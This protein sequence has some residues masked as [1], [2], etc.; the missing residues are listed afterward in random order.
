MKQY[1]IQHTNIQED[2]QTTY[3]IKLF[4]KNTSIREETELFK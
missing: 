1:S 3:C 2:S 4:S